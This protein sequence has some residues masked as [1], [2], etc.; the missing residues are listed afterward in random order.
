VGLWVGDG[1]LA[2]SAWKFVVWWGICFL[3][4][5]V[6]VIFALYDALAVIREERE[7]SD[8]RLAKALRESKN[9][10]DE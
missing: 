4:A 10:G 5:T 6:L 3:L 2:E 9:T 8:A 1:L 7:N